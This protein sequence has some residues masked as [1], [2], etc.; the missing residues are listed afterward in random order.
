MTA[1][2]LATVVAQM[3]HAQTEYFRTRS[4]SALID[5]KRLET[6][7]DRCCS[8]ILGSQKDMFDKEDTKA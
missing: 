6:K 3:R 8:Q 2:E 5:A 4:E 7:V 1:Q